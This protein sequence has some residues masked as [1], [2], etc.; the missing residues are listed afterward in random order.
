MLKLVDVWMLK[1]NT[2]FAI[3]DERR[4]IKLLYGRMDRNPRQNEIWIH[5]DYYEG[6]ME[7]NMPVW[8]TDKLTKSYNTYE[9]D[10]VKIDD[11]IDTFTDKCEPKKAN[12][13]DKC[14]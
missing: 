11:I 14:E 8:C 1:K 2:E 3:D 9:G 4:F 5:T 12:K 10:A 6:Y 7:V 13:P